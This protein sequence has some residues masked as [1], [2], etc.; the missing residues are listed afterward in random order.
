M[1]NQYCPNV[2]RL[3][4]FILLDLIDL[5]PMHLGIDFNSLRLLL[6]SGS[7]RLS[8]SVPPRGSG[9]VRTSRDAHRLPTRYREVVLTCSIGQLKL[10][11]NGLHIYV[12][13][14]GHVLWKTLSVLWFCTSSQPNSS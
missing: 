10:G 11:D 12:S 6:Q 2:D 14:N 7:L 1:E 5:T 3:I 4:V 9:W 13:D 8:R